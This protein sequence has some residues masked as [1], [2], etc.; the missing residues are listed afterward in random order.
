[1]QN[2]LDEQDMTNSLVFKY[3]VPKLYAEKHYENSRAAT[4]VKFLRIQWSRTCWNIPSK[5]K[6]KLL[7]PELHTVKRKRHNTSWATLH[8]TKDNAY[9]IYE[10]SLIAQL[11]KNPPAM[12]QMLVRFPSR[13]DLL[14]KG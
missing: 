7:N 6:C 9:H 4:S 3:N 12:Q 5:V 13:E 2:R 14:E 10:A 8:F 11:E 1:M